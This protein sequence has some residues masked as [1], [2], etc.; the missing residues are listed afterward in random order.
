MCLFKCICQVL[1]DWVTA[2]DIRIVFNRLSADQS[3]LYGLADA[4]LQDGQQRVRRDNTSVLELTDGDEGSLEQIR[5][6][7]HYALAELAVGGRCK[8]NGHA[9]RCVIDRMG[10]YACDCKHATTGV[11]CDKCLPFHHDRPWARASADNANPCI[12]QCW[13]SWHQKHAFSFHAIA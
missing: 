8:C 10:R 12:G 7:Y 2:T 1:Q 3:V 5:A 11:D 9:S 4:E 13:L 6:R